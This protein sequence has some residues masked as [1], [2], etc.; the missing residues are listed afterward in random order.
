MLYAEQRLGLHRSATACCSRVWAVG[1]LLGALVAARLR[2]PVRRGALLRV[3]PADRDRH[4]VVLATT[5]S[6]WVAAAVL[7]LFGV[8]TT[9]WGVVTM[10]I[11]QRLVPDGLRGRVGSTYSMLDLGGAALG[12]LLGGALAAVTSLTAPFWLG[13]GRHDGARRPG[14]APPDRPDPR[15][16]L[17]ARVRPPRK[18]SRRPHTVSCRPVSRS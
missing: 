10:S 2:G 3:G 11:R 13:R 7:V 8:H 12:T 5:R 16:G 17:T 15:P 4:E 1:G 14:L 9:V 6:P 18:G